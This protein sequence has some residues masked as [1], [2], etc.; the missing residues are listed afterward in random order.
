MRLCFQLQ[1]THESK[2]RVATGF[3]VSIASVPLCA[4]CHVLLC[5]LLKLLP[6]VFMSNMPRTT[7]NFQSGSALGFSGLRHVISLKDA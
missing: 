5:K 6:T 2:D 7:V 4:K 1:P 3:D